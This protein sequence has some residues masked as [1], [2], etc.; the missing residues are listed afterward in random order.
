M[1]TD[2]PNERT[3][4]K[5]AWNARINVQ[6]AQAIN[7]N[8]RNWERR[9]SEKK[10][11]KNIRTYV[12]T[13]NILYLCG[14]HNISSSSFV[15]VCVC[16]R[17]SLQMYGASAPVK[18]VFHQFHCWIRAYFHPL[19]FE[20]EKDAFIEYHEF[21]SSAPSYISNQNSSKKLPKKWWKHS[22][23]KKNEYDI[24]TMWNFINCSE[25][26]CVFIIL[27]SIFLR[28]QYFPLRFLC[29]LKCYFSCWK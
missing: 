24:Q 8:H 21:K 5:C 20:I 14:V 4:R 12:R 1:S 15:F 23:F 13:Q 19:N 6:R 22:F 27:C 26:Y 3:K 17:V 10:K 2:R 16:E 9:V 28:L 25:F 7:K 11:Q 29:H 18:Y